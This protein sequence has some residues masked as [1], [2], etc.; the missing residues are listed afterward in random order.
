MSQNTSTAVMARRKEPHDSL[1]YFPTPPWAT[2]ALCEHVIS[3]LNLSQMLVWEPA[4]GEGYMA[5]ALAEYFRGVCRTDVQRY[6]DQHGLCDFLLFNAKPHASW[7]D[8]E[9]DWIITN[10]PFRLAQE[11]ITTALAKCKLG[12]AVLVRTAFLEGIDRHERLF[13]EYPPH[14]IAQFAERVPMVRGRVDEDASSAT[15]YCWVIWTKNRVARST[16][17]VWIPPCRKQ[18]EREGDYT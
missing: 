12:V 13:T 14:I 6:D 18:L 15:A 11:F 4:C 8:V 10:P 1:D 5:R 7:E 3:G 9:F 17:F 2:R 16:E